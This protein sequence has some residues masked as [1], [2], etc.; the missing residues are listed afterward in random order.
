M[1]D[2]VIDLLEQRAQQFADRPAVVM[3][4]SGTVIT[5]DELRRRSGQL[6]NFLGSIGLRRGDV[7]GILMEN[8]AGFLEAAWAA[9]RSGL[10]YTAVNWH[11]SRE[12]VEYI[13]E[14]CGSRV[15][16]TSVAMR[17]LVGQLSMSGV[18]VVLCRDGLLPESTHDW[19]AVE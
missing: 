1:A 15:L 12:E 7:I 2:F 17:D 18:E 16:V 4:A 10:Y 13:L 11:L 14:D 3:G 9:Q 5:F 6:A 19:E 8:Q